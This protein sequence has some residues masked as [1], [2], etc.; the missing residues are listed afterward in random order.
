MLRHRHA[1][2]FKIRKQDAE[3]YVSVYI[4]I[5][6]HNNKKIILVTVHWPT[7]LQTTDDTSLY[8]EVHSQLQGKNAITIG[9]FNC[10]NA[11]W[12]LLTADQK[13]PNS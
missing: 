13:V 1:R 12:G 5:T 3:K 4:E 10:S 11:D 2:C 9:D 8:N 6:T 7:T